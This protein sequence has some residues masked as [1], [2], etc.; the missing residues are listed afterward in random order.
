MATRGSVPSTQ[1]SADLLR[2]A[3]DPAAAQ[4]ELS[5]LNNILRRLT[6]QVRRLEAV[7]GTIVSG[8]D[9]AAL[10]HDDFG[11]RELPE[12]HEQYL[13]T[14]GSRSI[15]GHQAVNPGIHV[16]GVDVGAHT[17]SGAIGHGEPVT[18]IEETGGPT[19]L[20]IG[21]IVDGETLV[22]SGA[23]IV[24]AAGVPAAA[25]NLLSATHSDT[26]TQSAVDGVIVRGNATPA[27]DGLAAPTTSG[28]VLTADTAIGGKL[29]WRPPPVVYQFPAIQ[30]I[31]ISLTTTMAAVSE[32][33][34]IDDLISANVKFYW[35]GIASFT[36]P[37]TLEWRITDGGLTTFLS[38][39]VVMAS[40]PFAF[41]V[42]DTSSAAGLP[43]ACP[44][45]ARLEARVTSGTATIGQPF[46]HAAW[47]VE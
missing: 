23:T 29:R 10:L 4:R 20:A 45:Y 15:T 36:A 37:K 2:H 9:L 43:I 31:A 3:K 28:H 27:W 42:C 39:S 26:V 19:D 16:D 7:S 5:N 13:M 44:G 30:G 6:E 35:R 22:R 12:N 32:L 41:T 47:R 8:A 1:L 18:A 34:C 14:D 33:C 40:S 11:G 46:Y 38:G 21:A 25:H 17:H 24:S